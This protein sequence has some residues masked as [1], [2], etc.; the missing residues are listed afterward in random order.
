MDP[1][2]NL[3]TSV[4]LGR[5][6]RSRLPRFGAAM[7]ITAGI[8]PDLDF[9]S[10][11]WGPAAFLRFHRSLLH[12]LLGSVA[13]CCFIAGAYCWLGRVG[14]KDSGSGAAK[15]DFYSAFVV[16]LTGAGAHIILDLAGGIG[17]RFLWPFREGWQS[18]DLFPSFDI[19]ILLMLAA[20]LAIPH[21][22][23]M[24]SD[25]IGEHKRGA[26][27]R[28][29][30]IATLALIVLYAG[31]REILH[32]RAIGLLQSR[33]YHG[34]P[35]E[36]AGAFPASSSNP[37][38]WRGLVSTPDAIEELSISLLPGATFDSDHAVPHYKP[39]QAATVAM[40]QNTPD[41]RLFLNYARFPLASIEP[42]ETGF[43]VTLRDLRFPAGDTS[44]E[45]ILL[46]A[47]FDANSQMTGQRLRFASLAHHRQ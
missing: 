22:G 28:P 16:C 25:E 7:L 8:A 3:V 31:G 36:K 20:G 34:Q 17:V 43:D 2:T 10:Y 30:A 27:G 14:K 38:A 32:A 12:S 42:E 1:V 40:V 46:E 4:A 26:P 44:V 18:W 9:V 33:D 39:D 19:W 45:D 11:F 47:H 37:F 6:V 24:V 21:L 35:P 29:A 23:R 15:L 13:M 5:S 41:G